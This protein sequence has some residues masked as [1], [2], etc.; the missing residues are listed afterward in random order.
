M[1]RPLFSRPRRDAEPAVGGEP[2]PRLPEPG[3]PAGTADHAPAE[4]AG[5]DAQPAAADPAS[6]RIPL[7]PPRAQDPPGPEPTTLGP[8][9]APSPVASGLGGAAPRSPGEPSDVPHPTALLKTTAVTEPDGLGV[10]DAGAREP[11]RPSFRHRGRVRRRLRYLRRVRELAFRDLGG[12]TFDLHRFGRDGSALVAG[13]LEAL[14]SVDAELRTLQSALDD[15]RE[16]VVLREPGV[17]A[18]PACA[19]LHGSE[20]HFCPHCGLALSGRRAAAHGDR[21]LEGSLGSGFDGP[22][23]AHPNSALQ[24]NPD[25][26]PSA[27]PGRSAPIP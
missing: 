23:A 8:S 22:A 10:L 24:A 16:Y 19:A 26:S 6:I 12:L 20:A 21:G 5:H 15:H 14:S 2:L 27:L 11:A 9:S 1:T 7:A 18:C 3:T 13:K 4:P 25:A 17:A